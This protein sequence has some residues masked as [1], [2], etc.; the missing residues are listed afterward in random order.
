MSAHATY[1]Q[2]PAELLGQT[3]S[4][5]VKIGEA[6]IHINNFLSNWHWWGLL[7]SNSHF[8][9]AAFSICFFLAFALVLAGAV[10]F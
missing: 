2:T 8:P 3:S 9:F 6:V 5:A 10:E 1:I 7:V 4:N